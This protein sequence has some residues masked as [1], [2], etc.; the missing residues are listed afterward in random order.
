MGYTAGESSRFDQAKAVAAQLVKDSRRGDAISLILMGS[1]PR[2]VIA[3]PTQNLSVVKKEID[4]LTLSDGG[5]DLATTF[6]KVNSRPRGFAERPERGR[7]S[8]RPPDCELAAAG[9]I[10][11]QNQARTGQAR[12]LPAAFGGDR[13]RQ[14]GGR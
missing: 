1:P 7:F 6:E 8:D 10:R 5:T 12:N 4:E 2:V 11:R 3:D 9:R 13:P 14:I